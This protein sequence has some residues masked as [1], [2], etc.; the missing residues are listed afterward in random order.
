VQV[1]HSLGPHRE[2]R[3]DQVLAFFDD[4]TIPFD[5]NQAERDLRTLKV[6]QK[7]SGCFR[8]ARG[9]EAFARLRGYLSTPRKLGHALLPALQA[10]FA[11][12]PLYRAR[13]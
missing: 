4:L 12:Q 8:A 5:N 10:V 3:Q 9:G 1:I 13:N 2:E 7:V 11:G 6:Q